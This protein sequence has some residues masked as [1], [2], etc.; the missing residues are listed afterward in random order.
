LNDPVNHPAHYCLDNGVELIQILE[1]LNY[2]RGA[3]IKYIFRAG[4]KDSSKEIED[5]R[6]AE[7]MIKREINRITESRKLDNHT[8]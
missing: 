1:G 5:L 6:K 4:K 8:A 2:C 3:A 7:W